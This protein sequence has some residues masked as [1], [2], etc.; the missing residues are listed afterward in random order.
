MPTLAGDV[1]FVFE[2]SGD[3]V[4]WTAATF[5][6]YAEPGVA[7]YTAPAGDGGVLYGRTR[8]ELP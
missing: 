6:G 4:N 7:T 1:A 5:D 8:V 2:V 3:L